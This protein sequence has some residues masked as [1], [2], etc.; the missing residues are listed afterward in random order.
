MGFGTIGTYIYIWNEKQN[1]STTVCEEKIMRTSQGVLLYDSGDQILLRDSKE[2]LDFLL[3]TANRTKCHNSIAH[4]VI[5]TDHKLHVRLYEDP[6]LIPTEI[7]ERTNMHGMWLNVREHN[8]FIRDE[9]TEQINEE[10]HEI[11]RLFCTQ[12]RHEKYLVRLLSE[13]SPIW[14]GRFLNMSTCTG[15]KIYGDDIEYFQ[16]KP[17]IITIPNITRTECGPQPNVQGLAVARDG[18]TLVPFTPCAW[19][20]NLATFGN[21]AYTPVKNKWQQVRIKPFHWGKHPRFAEL[22]YEAE[23]DDTL[24]MGELEM[25][26]MLTFLHELNQKQISN[27]KS[28]ATSTPSIEATIFHYPVLRIVLWAV[29]SSTVIT[30][31][32]LIGITVACPQILRVCCTG[33]TAT[34]CLRGRKRQHKQVIECRQYRRNSVNDNILEESLEQLQCEPHTMYVYDPTKP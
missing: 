26:H 14:A 30:I 23:P 29:I 24:H 12:Q 13:F 25:G 4:T 32:I 33:C 8:Q 27:Y 7:N 3:H 21:Y 5:G 31:C 6:K 20:N 11:I 15:I 18:I 9:V 17:I 22:T 34:V 28:R 19:T 16:C 10:Y 1:I 2:Q